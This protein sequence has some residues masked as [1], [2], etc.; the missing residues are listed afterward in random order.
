RWPCLTMA[1]DDELSHRRS[2][3]LANLLDGALSHLTTRQPS[4]TMDGLLYS[5]NRH[6]SVPRRLFF[7][8]RLTPLERNAWQVFR[9]QINGDGVT[10]LPTYEQLRPWLASM[11][12]DAQASSETVARALTLL[13][14]TRWL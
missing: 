10:A 5:G 2:D 8:R 14:L 7:D 13:R 12:C 3:S 11:P 4:K 9:L 6:E 1:M